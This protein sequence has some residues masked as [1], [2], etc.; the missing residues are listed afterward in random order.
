MDEHCATPIH[1]GLY[2][3]FGNA[4][5]VVS[6]DAGVGNLLLLIG[7]ISDKG[8]G[9][10]W[11]IVTKVTSNA[12]CACVGEIVLETVFA[13]KCCFCRKGGLVKCLAQLRGVIDKDGST[14]ILLG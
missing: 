7:A 8:L 9:F 5:L 11:V 6:A 4:V 10:K 13:D 12:V 1:D 3:T 2:L 14:A